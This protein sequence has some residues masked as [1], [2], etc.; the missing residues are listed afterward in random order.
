MVLVRGSRFVAAFGLLVA[1]GGG[2]PDVPI[3]VGN[4]GSGGGTGSGGAAPGTGGNVVVIPE[5]GAAGEGMGTG[6][7]PS[8]PCADLVCGKGQRCEVANGAAACVDNTC[9]DLKCGA[10]EECQP[11]TGG[12]F[13]CTSVA[14]S[15]D[16]ECPESRYC[17]GKKCVDDVCEAETRACQGDEVLVC[18][19]NGGTVTPAYT[20]G[21]GG[22]FTSKC[23][24]KAGAAAMSIGCTC[25]GDWDCPLYTTCEAGVCKGTGVEPTCTLPPARFEDVLP[26]LEFRWGGLNKAN[27]TATGR[28]FPWSAQVASTPVVI[29]L[30]D[31]NGDG[32]IN[33]LDFPEILFMTYDTAVE[34]RGI[35]R[36]V[37]GG[38][39]HKG[40]DYFALCGSTLWREGA[41]VITD[42]DPAAGD[43]ESRSAALG[44][45]AGMLAAGDLD[46]DGRPEIL[47]PLQTG[48]LQILD[49]TGQIIL[50]T[51]TGLWPSVT[52][53]GDWRYP[54]VAI[55]NLDYAG[56]AEIVVG[57]RVIT[58]KSAAGKL[59]VDKVFTGQYRT[60]TM[61]H[62]DDEQHHGPT[63]C[64]ADLTSSP[65]LEIVAGT[66][67]YRLPAVA[68]CTAQ[69]MSDY[70]QNRLTSVWN[71]ETVNSTATFYPEGFC[72]VA[73][74]LG[75][76]T[77]AAPGPANKLDQVPE[78]LVMAD[79]H[80]LILQAATGKLLRD[81]N[82]GGGIQGGAP[83]VDDFDGDGFPEIAT[84][85]S[86]FYS[87][88]DLQEANATNCPAW[89]AVLGTAAKPP[90]T[91]PARTPGGACTK[92]ADCNAGAVCNQ[93]AGTCVCLQSGWK[94]DTEDDS[95]KVTSSSVFD[96]N[97]DGAAEVVY[98][99]ECYF[100]VYDGASGGLYLALPSLS[101]TIVENPVVAD[102]DNDG[103]AEIVFV[104]N[105]ETIQCSEA[106]LDSWPKGNNDV[107]ATSLP[108]GLEVW[109]DPSD[110]W[111]AA[112]RVWNE[113]SYHVTNVTEGGQIPLHE[114]EHYKPL[115]GRLYN[116]YRSQPRNYGVAPDLIPI[117]IQISS[118]DVA[119]G[120]LSNQIEISVLVKNAGD[121]RV[122]PG[123]QIAFDGSW[124]TPTATAPLLDANGDPITVTL[125]KSLEP[126]AS[127][128]VSVT[129]AAGSNGRPD[130]PVEVRATVDAQQAERE[131]H[132]D[133]NSIAAPVEAGA[134]L[135]D[136]IV[137]VDKAVGCSPPVATVAVA[138][139]G[140]AEAAN[141]V[142]RIYAGDP[143][144]GGQII[145]EM[146]LP[147]P[148]A[149]G[150]RVSF[151][152]EL[153]TLYRNVT[154]YASVDPLNSVA[155]CNDANN[156]APGP[157]LNCAVL[158]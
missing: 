113:H 126:G 23:S 112:R 135:A 74:V 96:F 155:E 94:R 134:A 11:A 151:Q 108:N 55:A 104:Q 101:R 72:A 91:N 124:M 98:N 67:L 54:T 114:P 99:D 35:V 53:T 84:A 5:A 127:T 88:I 141:I 79:G 52:N 32:L 30:D 97:G 156:I 63:V 8:D 65:G 115:N 27:P 12:G 149:P 131:C 43:A 38:G 59:A 100:H 118:P 48:A 153:E 17:D 130:L 41:P 116:T 4:G 51:A 129:Y 9:A 37:H 133:N 50:T 140:S 33:E 110:V 128:V 80:L 147:G 75:A 62:D 119:C 89:P 123:V 152:M 34:Q 90:G 150:E 139:L 2:K 102:V 117:A 39:P 122:G 19:S 144:R 10:L 93:K 20:C 77:A 137:S 42:C 70:C 3:V 25:E 47:V 87:V 56:F 1:C 58:L 103:N 46:G 145:G 26:K 64:L 21:G 7:A 158:R 105:N 45:G 18:G 109:G 60:G 125:D 148:L 24:D 61:H 76:D 85:L 22:Y 6:G 29:N 92:D 136:L 121:L 157:V 82:L 31:D 106:N 15:S 73:D 143:S 107:P 138:N 66:S 78:V 81:I 154:L 13:A 86:D 49:N 28:A 69:P 71:A 132:E 44:R 57:N 146:T 36:A 40:M 142:V 83:N 16:V 68:D 111:V 14:C 95:S 120:Q